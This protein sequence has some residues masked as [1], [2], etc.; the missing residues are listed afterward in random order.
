MTASDK[1]SMLSS[2]CRFKDCTHSTEA[3]CAVL[4][5][6]LNEVLD[7]DS[8][9]NYLQLKQEKTHFKITGF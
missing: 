7:K 1:I 3:G 9:E 8:Y 4:E 2:N 5:A 6:M